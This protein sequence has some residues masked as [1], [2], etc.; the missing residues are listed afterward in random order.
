MR[1][2]SWSYIL[3]FQ[4]RGWKEQEHSGGRG[5]R[6]GVGES[7]ETVVATE[8]E[9]DQKLGQSLISLGVR[10][11][12]DERTIRPYESQGEAETNWSGLSPEKRRKRARNSGPKSRL[13]S[14]ASA[15]AT[16][17]KPCTRKASDAAGKARRW[18]TAFIPPDLSQRRWEST[19]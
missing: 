19:R 3:L 5:A 10:K 7:W 11:S 9:K 8:K 13:M 14:N 16:V 17:V 2:F 12:G 6:G 1:A 15:N 4:K 18:L